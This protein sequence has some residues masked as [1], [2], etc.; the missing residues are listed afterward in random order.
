MNIKKY[1]NYLFLLPFIF[2]FLILLNWHH[3]IG[4]SIDDLFFY[5]IP[6]ETNIMSFVIER[7]DIWS[8]RILIEYIL[9]HILQSPLILW[10]YLDSLIFTFI[11]ILTYK[12][13]NGENKLFYSILSCILC[14]SF[15]FSSHYALGS[16]GFITTTI[17]YTWPLFS[18]LLAIYILKNHTAKDINKTKRILAYIIS[19]LCL[20]FAVNNEQLA[21]I[22]LGLFVLYYLLNY[23]TKINKKCYLI[24]ITSVIGIINTVIC[25]GIHKRYILELRWF[26]DYLQL[27]ILNKLNIG[28]S[29]I[30][31]RCVTWCD[32]TTLILLG[33]IA[34]CVYLLTKNK[35]QTITSL[36]PF[37]IASGF[38]ILTLTDNL[39]LIQIMNAN[40]VRYGYVPISIKRMIL[41]L[42]IYAIFIIAFLYS[43]YS[44]YKNQKSVL[45]PIYSIMFVGFASTIMFGFTP[46]TP[47]MERIYIFFYYGNMLAIL[48]FIKQIIEKRIKT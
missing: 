8:S 15:I 30:I 28:F 42:T 38:W 2:L 19:V 20:M 17:N 9:C 41:S 13:I 24:G 18:G 39:T 43:L 48:I 32:L 11:A 35:K 44:I 40:I 21:V 5:T 31:N 3:S 6:Q 12:L 16:A 37:I 47:S 4:L 46:S 33:I 22:L 1:K 34:I 14:L 29:H 25:P 23:K 45:W 10:W 36:I 26:P 27:N 7:Y